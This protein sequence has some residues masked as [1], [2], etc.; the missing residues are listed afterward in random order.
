MF[1][2]AAAADITEALYGNRSEE[3]SVYRIYNNLSDNKDA[4]LSVAACESRTMHV[5]KCGH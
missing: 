2:N 5:A 3:F 4:W 1:C